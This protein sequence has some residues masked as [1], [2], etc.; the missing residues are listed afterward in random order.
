MF[1]H[2]ASEADRLTAAVSIG[3]RRGDGHLHRRGPDVRPDGGV[4]QAASPRLHP[5]GREE[6]ELL[7]RHVCGAGHPEL[8]SD[9]KF[10]TTGLELN[11]KFSYKI[12]I[13]CFGPND[14]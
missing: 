12:H 14:Q 13:L 4:Q 11:H 1:Q 7:H 9:G 8:A 6:S 3:H 5:A 2:I 10:G